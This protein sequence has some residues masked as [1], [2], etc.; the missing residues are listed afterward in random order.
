[1]T[2]SNGMMPQLGT[3]PPNAGNYAT[4]T[5][6]KYGPVGSAGTGALTRNSPWSRDDSGPIDSAGS[7]AVPVV[8]PPISI[9]FEDSHCL[10]IVKPPGQ[11]TQGTWAPPGEL[12][13]EAAVRRYLNPS[14]PRAVYL[15]MVHRLDRPASGVLIWAKT[16]KAA[17][18][19]SSQFEQRRVVKEYWAI[20][21][22]NRSSPAAIWP[23]IGPALMDSRRGNLDRL[24]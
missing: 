21:E 5:D 20:V 13:L 24:G 7:P 8:N 3:P 4:P 12:T 17:R 18:R 9:L 11:L 1:M 19:L 23:A 16:S 15:G 14:D 2:A 10:A 22:W 6:N